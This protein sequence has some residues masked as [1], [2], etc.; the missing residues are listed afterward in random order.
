MAGGRNL[1][2][3]W[4]V[5]RD[6]DQV[7]LIDLAFAERPR[8][9]T[10]GALEAECNAVARGLRRRGFRRGDRIGILA[11]NRLEY[12]AA[13]FGTM[14]AG[15]VTVPISIKLP[16]DAI[17]YI[18]RDSGAK[19]LFCDRD[20][21]PLCP[22]DIPLVDFDDPAGY[23]ALRDPGAFELI[24][25]EADE[26]GMQLY[27]SGSTGRPK[28]VPLSHATQWWAL[29]VFRQMYGE[30]PQHRY[31]VAAPMFHMNA[32]VSVKLALSSHASIVL[33]PQFNARAYAEAIARWRVTWL[34]S[35][36]TMIAL[37]LRE[38]DL[39]TSLDFSSVERIT[40]GSAPL[41]Q[42]LIDKVQAQFPNAK[43]NNSYGT[44]EG[45]PVVFGPHPEGKRRPELAAGYP[46][47]GGKVE[48]REGPSPDEGVLYM[49]NPSVMK[50]YHNLPEQT[51]K[52][53]KDGWYRSGDIF[54][55]D[56]DG[57]YYFLG[58]ADDMFN[59]GAENIWPGEVEKMLE[60]LDGVHQAFV[61]P[62]PD[63]I[64]GQIPFAFIVP[65]PGAALDETT[66]KEFALRNGPAYA[67]PRFV[68]IVPEL[69]LAATNKVD[70]RGL[71]KRAEEI[72]A[73]RR[74]KRA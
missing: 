4:N 6:A 12:L 8:E 58:R 25:P 64:K 14:R 24:E 43:I 62:V 18:V 52:V 60:R 10:Y 61:V 22:A 30:M 17:D 65:R 46:A 29:D 32:T 15:L 72:V 73:V 57:F 49:R 27:T 35:V 13:F 39:M 66:V 53:L 7:A 70:R 38:T 34:T 33:L 42:A 50:G 9:V 45:G 23:A 16:R 40:M 51:A 63:E 20:R 21:R 59:C 2:R 3:V 55:R 68:E 54:R 5:A 1:G 74:A 41:T 36:P 37:M 69:T 67:H 48:L 26:V 44:T 11:L 19:L 71:T 56:E 28:G 31:L 47:P